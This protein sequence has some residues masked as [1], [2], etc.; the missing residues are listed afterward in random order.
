[1]LEKRGFFEGMNMD[2][3]EAAL[4]S[5]MYRYALN[6]RNGN[7]EQ[8]AEG[9]ITIAEGNQEV[10][11]SLPSGGNRVIMAYDDEANDRVLYM[12]Y[13]SDGNNRFLGYDYKNSVINTIVSDSGN[14]LGIDPNFL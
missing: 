6:I 4:S 7:S 14:T 11:I 13:N 5:N 1:M 8:G 9:V 12:V 3:D 2:L 10:S